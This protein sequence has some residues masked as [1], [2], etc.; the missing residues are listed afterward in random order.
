MET[1]LNTSEITKLWHESRLK[2]TDTYTNPPEI[3]RIDDSVIGTLGNFSAST[4]KAKSK[5]TF[6]VTAIVAAAMCNKTILQYS[7][8]LP[9]NKEKVLYVDTEQSPFHCKHVI[10]RILKLSNQ[11][12]E[13]HPQ[14]L[15]FL[16]LRKYSP[17]IRIQIIEAAVYNIEGIGLL[18]I[19]GIRDLA[20]DINSPSEATNLI[21]KLMKWTDELNIHIHTVLHQNKGDN[22]TRGH[23]GTELNNKAETILQ[24]EKNNSDPNISI[25]SP[26]HIRSKEFENFA[27]KIN[28]DSLPEMVDDFVINLQKSKKGSN[29][30]DIPEKDHR[31]A[32]LKTFKNKEEMKYGDLIAAIKLGYGFMGYN[33]GNNNISKL[34]VF[35]L[36]KNMI[37]KATKTYK[38]NSKFIF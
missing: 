8:N 10:E 27:F 5:K 19:D 32:L 30:I 6:N 21:S 17:K 12:T 11:T 31:E 14:K 36:N 37:I 35:I 13:V 16:S 25:V 2:I 33:F 18:V 34:R 24:I 38:Y 9:L 4:G 15:E 7:V 20:Y 23:L 1:N 22:N 26:T 29:F 28:D 3:L